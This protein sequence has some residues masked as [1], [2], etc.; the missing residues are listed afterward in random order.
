MIA[1][2]NLEFASLDGTYD[3]NETAGTTGDYGSYI[4]TSARYG[5]YYGMEDW[6][7]YDL[8]MRLK[9]RVTSIETSDDEKLP[10][11]EKLFMGGIGSVRG[12]DAYSIMFATGGKKSASASIE[13]SIPLSEAAKM[14][15]T[16]F[17]DYG[18]IGQDTFGEN[19]R[20][21][22]G[23]VVEWQ[24]GFGPI[25]LVFAQALDDEPGDSTNSFEFSM[26]TKF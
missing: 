9:A 12:Y 22:A 24:S 6:I 16:G 13:A 14:R 4:K 10:I 7:E 3:I 2:V 11:A 18:M 1:A 15:L 26:G 17:Y 5:V 25:N 8:I 21:S 20:S 19:K 23:V